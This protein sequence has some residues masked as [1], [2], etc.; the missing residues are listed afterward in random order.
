M[1][2]SRIFPSTGS[3]LSGLLLALLVCFACA[4]ARADDSKSIRNFSKAIAALAPD[5]D[6]AEAE[7]VSVTSH[8][9][10]RRLAKEW[11]V[12]PPA[13]FQNFLIHIGRRQYGY[14]FHWARGIGTELRALH[15]KTLV[16]HWAAA[17]PGTNLEHNVVVV[18]ARGQDMR[19][20]YIIDGWRACG[21]LI[22]WPVKTDTYPWK[23][24]LPET[25]WLQ[26]NGGSPKTRASARRKPP[27]ERKTLVGSH[28]PNARDSG[29]L[30]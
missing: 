6:P 5:V 26:D 13:N 28:D 30:E 24:D 7:A 27:N 11:R 19:D 12:V 23:E 8:T 14:C 18:T 21:R 25:A 2:L 20:G 9:T 29:S 15:L 4:P 1:Q 22:W 10:A 16:L 3:A 17:D